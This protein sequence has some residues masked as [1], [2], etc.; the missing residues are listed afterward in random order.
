MRKIEDNCGIS[1]LQLMENAGKGIYKTLKE[2]FTN[3]K[4][5]RIL[6]VAY[7]GNNG[8]DGFV[9]ARYLCE[10][11]ETDI[12]FIGDEDKF[13]EE[14][15]ANFK[16]IEENNK[17][18]LLIEA[19]QVDFN[20]YDVIIDAILGTGA[21]GEVKEP[22]ASVIDEINNSTAFKVAVDVPSGI[23]AD[24]GEA[25][26]KAVNADLIITFHDIKQGLE[27]FKDKVIIIDIGIK[28]GEKD[29]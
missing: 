13:K 7:H 5:K 11:A 12:L 18:Q 24:T 22:I 2:K 29:V 23:N 25:I 9:A 28:G 26:N 1:K 6:I 27:R 10:E 20:D 21:S 16:K 4:D 19:E 15:A 3:L 8:G 17:I 14:A